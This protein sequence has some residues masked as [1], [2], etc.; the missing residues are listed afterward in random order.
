M[1]FAFQ[2]DFQMAASELNDILDAAHRGLAITVIQVNNSGGTLPCPFGGL[3]SASANQ[4][5]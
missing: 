3:G 5:Q 2:G 1:V 4:Q